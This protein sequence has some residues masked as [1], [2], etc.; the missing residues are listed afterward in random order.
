MFMS[1]KKL[2][3]QG[4]QPSEFTQTYLEDKLNRI[5]EQAPY[6][7]NLDA[8]FTRRGKHFKGVVSIY[9]SVGRFFARSNGTQLKEVSNLLIQQLS[10]QLQK[11][12][13]NR[14]KRVNDIATT[15]YN[16]RGANNESETVA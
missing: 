12:K 5:L 6:G 8:V 3:F 10:R 4:F 9:S 11:W 7:A 2:K 15:T 13:S 16:T 14:F 1:Q